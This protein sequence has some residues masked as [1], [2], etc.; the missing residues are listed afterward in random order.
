MMARSWANLRFAALVAALV[1]FTLPVA[2][3]DDAEKPPDNDKKSQSEK[4][5]TKN[6]DKSQK[7]TDESTDSKFMRVTRD[8][9]DN[10]I[11]METATKRYVSADGS[12]VV[13]LVG[14]IHIADADYFKGLNKDFEQ[15]DALLFELVAPEG[16][17]PRK[18][19]GKATGIVSGV[20]NFMK[21]ML[22]LEF[23]LDQVDYEKPNF[24]HADMTPNEFSKV[25]KDRGESPIS[26]F[27][28]LMQASAEAQANRKRPPPP[29]SELLTVIFDKERGPSILKRMMADEMSEADTMLEA[30]NGEEGS[31]LITERN[32]VA[33]KVLREQIDAG[34]K[35]IGVFYGA[36]HM[37]DMEKR[38]I[39]DFGLKL[40]ETRWLTAWDLKKAAPKKPA[41]Q[42]SKKKMAKSIAIKSSAN[43]D[44]PV[45]APKP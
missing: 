41:T 2:R 43:D 21:D 32:K 4:T 31:T 7:E 40:Q 1:F 37:V 25:M 27:L 39:K 44:A 9:D 23:Q 28:R 6:P 14:A 38:L 18:G 26:I 13:D 20:Q 22:A 19:R 33:L 34:K 15:Y 12:L 5:A 10:P 8:K 24:V 35:K 36:G 3:G 42:S 45:V 11:A 16:S 29:A 30:L 17:V